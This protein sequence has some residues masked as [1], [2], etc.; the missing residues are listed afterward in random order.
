MSSYKSA[1]IVGSL[2]IGA[3]GPAFAEPIGM[4]AQLGSTADQA[5]VNQFR[6]EGN[7]FQPPGTDPS[8]YGARA[9]PTRGVNPND[10]ATMSLLMYDLDLNPFPVNSGGEVSTLRGNIHTDGGTNRNGTGRLK[11]QWDEVVINASRTLIRAFITTTNNEP[12]IPANAVVPQPGGGTAPAVYWSWHFGSVDPVNFQSNISR[13]T[14]RR[15]SMSQSSDAGITYFTTTTTTGTIPTRADWRPGVDNGSLLNS[16][17]DGT[18]F[19]LLQYEVEYVPSA[20]SLALL[21]VGL[22]SISSRRRR[23]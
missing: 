12:L 11:F 6:G 8:G 3:V 13:V 19:V 2:A 18:N 21:G 9:N 10:R 4:I 1:V 23:G 5:V 7:P 17:G 16:V 22:A 20:G 14:L 15:A